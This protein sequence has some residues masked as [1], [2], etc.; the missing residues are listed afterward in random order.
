MVICA[1]K[2][3]LNLE[4]LFPNMISPHPLHLLLELYK[5]FFLLE[6]MQRNF[7]AV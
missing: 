4:F 2:K 1:D 5:S 3:P 6:Q 7:Y